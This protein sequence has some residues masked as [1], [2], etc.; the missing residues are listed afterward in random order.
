M[1]QTTS[2]TGFTPL[3]C[4]AVWDPHHQTSHIQKFAGRVITQNWSADYESLLSSLK[5]NPL[6][7]RR[8]MQKLKLC[9]KVLNNK[10]CI[11]SSL[12][13]PHPHPSLRCSNSNQIYTPYVPIY[14]STQILILHRNHQA[15][16]MELS[17]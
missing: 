9:Y 7:T 4:S 12:F 11:P 6:A 16:A 3:Y 8:R 17:T 10:S 15:L 13:T 5:L 14:L 1:P 2:D